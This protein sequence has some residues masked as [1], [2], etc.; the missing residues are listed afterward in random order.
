MDK[1]DISATSKTYTV[2]DIA[3][4]LKIG[5]GTTYKLVNSG[6]FR[7]MRIGSTIRISKEGFDR[8]TK[9]SVIVMQ[10]ASLLY[11]SL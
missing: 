8:Q 2:N 9:Q 3:A 11:Q 1:Q 4:I 6:A 5:H 7:I 10:A